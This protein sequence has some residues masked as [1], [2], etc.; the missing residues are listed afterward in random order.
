MD[1]FDNPDHARRSVIT[2]GGVARL[3]GLAGLQSL[4]ISGH[5]LPAS[6]T[7]LLLGFKSL[8]SLNIGHWQGFTAKHVQDFLNQMPSLDWFKFSM[9][10]TEK[11][12]PAYCRYA[13]V[14][15]HGR[16]LEWRGAPHGGRGINAAG[17]KKIKLDFDKIEEGDD[18]SLALRMSACPTPAH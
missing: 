18:P 2:E 11:S 6:C 13:P 7:R 17:I 4:K 10:F 15:M 16:K 8:R 12:Y 5:F 14:I 1:E 9:L 3:Q